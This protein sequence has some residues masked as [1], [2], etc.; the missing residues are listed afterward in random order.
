VA[1]PVWS[2]SDVDTHTSKLFSA[3]E[4]NA[5]KKRA[6]AEVAAMWGIV[7]AKLEKSKQ[8]KEKEELAKELKR[9]E[10]QQQAK[11]QPKKRTC[12]VLSNTR[13]GWANVPRWGERQRRW[14]TA[15]LPLP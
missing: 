8:N 14:L 15:L 11:K 12:L 3:E 13:R 7:K 9:Q 1:A 2:K 5:L 10:K 6:E 4:R